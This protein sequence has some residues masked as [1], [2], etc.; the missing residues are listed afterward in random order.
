MRKRAALAQAL[1]VRPNVVLMDE[2]FSDLDVQVRALMENELLDLWASTEASVV[3][4][5]HDI[6]E[7]IALADRVVVMTAGPARIKD[8]YTVDLPRP[9]NV[10]EIRFHHRFSELYREI[11]EDLRSE[12]LKNYECVR[13]PEIRR[14]R[15]S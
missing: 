5:T 2:P 9:R 14:I 3:F 10:S 12:V 15:Y 11:W 6:E 8:I 13:Q 4:V 1:I 7:A